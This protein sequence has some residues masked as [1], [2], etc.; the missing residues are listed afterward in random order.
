M[1]GTKRCRH[2]IYRSIYLT[3][4][5]R[6]LIQLSAERWISLRVVVHVSWLL[7][8]HM[9]TK[10]AE[11][12]LSGPWGPMLSHIWFVTASD[13]GAKVEYVDCVG[14]MKLALCVLDAYYVLDRTTSQNNLSEQHCKSDFGR[15]NGLEWSCESDLAR[16]ILIER[17]W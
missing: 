5:R 1:D 6:W 7:G 12:D 3:T 2:P 13:S 10:A 8:A 14:Q 15:A 4:L 9:T 16:A 11:N 17:F